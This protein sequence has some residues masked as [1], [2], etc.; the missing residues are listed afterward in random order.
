[1]N[2]RMGLIVAVIIATIAYFFVQHREGENT[3]QGTVT[4]FSQRAFGSSILF[5]LFRRHDKP[6]HLKQQVWL[7]ASDTNGFSTIAIFSPSTPISWMEVKVLKEF[8][9]NGGKL[10]V[11]AHS[12]STVR[13]ISPLVREFGTE[14]VTKPDL[15]FKNGQMNPATAESDSDLFRK[16]DLYHFYSATQFDVPTCPKSQMDCY[17][18]VLRYEKGSVTVILGLPPVANAL[19]GFVANR[20]VAFRM[21]TFGPLVIDEYHHFF[22]DKTFWDLMKKPAFGLT[23]VGIILTLLLYFFFAYTPFHEQTQVA[24]RELPSRSYHDLNRGLLRQILKQ[25]ERDPS[26][27]EEHAQF[28]VRAFPADRDE[29]RKVLSAILDTRDGKSS[30]AILDRARRLAAAHL[31]WLRNKGRTF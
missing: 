30:G 14:L 13:V 27:L 8:V 2:R 7:K 5:D 22:S 25:S 3:R 23:I 21:L 4:A 12:D 31:N 16:N 15:S 20:Q 26:V 10:I 9:K 19:I 11:S 29:L 17:V 1:M 18:K 6:V 28:I 24:P